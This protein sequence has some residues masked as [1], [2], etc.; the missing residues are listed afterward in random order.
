MGSEEPDS[1]IVLLGQPLFLRDG[2]SV[3]FPTRKSFAICLYL[4]AQPGIHVERQKLCG[5][6]W[7]EFEDEAARVSLRKAL[8]LIATTSIML[9][10][11]AT[12]A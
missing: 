5:L 2:R 6:L 9:T 12:I 8:S 1:E 7:A 11:P 10:A 3:Q 4:A